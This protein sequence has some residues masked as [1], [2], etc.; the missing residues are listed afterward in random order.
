MSIGLRGLLPRCRS[1]LRLPRGV[2][3][4]LALRLATR[5]DRARAG[6]PHASTR[7]SLHRH[8]CPRRGRGARRSVRS[9]PR[10]LPRPRRRRELRAMR[11]VH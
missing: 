7:A 6:C 11:A 3:T 8:P 10:P 1:M 5:E 9:H 2:G 4:S